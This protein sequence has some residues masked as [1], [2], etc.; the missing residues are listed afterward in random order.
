L[1]IFDD[2]HLPAEK[3]KL[4]EAKNLKRV[5]CFA[6]IPFLYNIPNAYGNRCATQTAQW[7]L[8]VPIMPHFPMKI[9]QNHMEWP[10]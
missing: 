8:L 9:G 2:F 4:D 6:P 10:M 3:S 1:P 5:A 7:I